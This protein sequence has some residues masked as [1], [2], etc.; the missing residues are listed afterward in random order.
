MVRCF[1]RRLTL[2]RG[3]AENMVGGLVDDD[4]FCGWRRSSVIPETRLIRQVLS[5]E[6]SVLGTHYADDDVCPHWHPAPVVWL[7]AAS[8]FRRG[9]RP[10][11][12]SGPSSSLNSAPVKIFGAGIGRSAG[13]ASG[14]IVGREGQ[15]ITAEGVFFWA[16]IV[17]G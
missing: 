6:Y 13:Y 12:L 11:R 5:T 14:I 3:L 10:L 4:G 15:I 17:C 8:L 7:L 1:V 9:Q 16:P 2:V